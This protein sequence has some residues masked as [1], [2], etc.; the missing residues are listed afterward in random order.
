VD[1]SS[2]RSRVRRPGQPCGGLIAIAPAA[3]SALV[4]QHGARRR[5]PDRWW[6]LGD[7]CLADFF[8]YPLKY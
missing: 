8:D 6:N 5:S 4:T 1:A 2:T 7:R 3:E